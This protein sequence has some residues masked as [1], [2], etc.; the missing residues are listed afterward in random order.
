MKTKKTDSRKLKLE[1]ETLKSLE[2]TE[3]DRVQGGIGAGTEFPCFSHNNC[4]A[5]NV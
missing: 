3:L 2:T 4:P 1:Q 5:P